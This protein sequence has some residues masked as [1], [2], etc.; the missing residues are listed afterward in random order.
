MTEPTP[1]QSDTKQTQKQ[2]PQQTTDREPDSVED[3]PAV[4][5]GERIATGKGIARGGKDSG[6]VPGADPQPPDGSK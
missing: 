2:K 4:D 6:F 1:T 5:R 3:V